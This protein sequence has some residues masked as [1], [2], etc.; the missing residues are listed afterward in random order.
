MGPGKEVVVR[1]S[2][3]EYVAEIDYVASQPPDD[4][5]YSL[6]LS[7][8]SVRYVE[9]SEILRLLHLLCSGA[10]ERRGTVD[11]PVTGR[12]YRCSGWTALRGSV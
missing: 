4:W 11:S 3:G 6:S 10:Q 2:K 9:T 12:P 5:T 7:W 1:Y 8:H